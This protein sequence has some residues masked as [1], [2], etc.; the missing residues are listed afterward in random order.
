MLNYEWKK[1]FKLCYK[2]VQYALSKK[3]EDESTMENN[4]KAVTDL[5]ELCEMYLFEKGEFHDT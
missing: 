1:A 3:W 2:E 5:K 4:K